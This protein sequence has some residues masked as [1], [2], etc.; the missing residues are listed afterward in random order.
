M[1]GFDENYLIYLRKSR[2]DLEAEAR[3]EGET[4]ARHERALLELAR[5]QRLNVT[6]IYRE[7]VSGETIASRPVMQQVLSE[8]EE[9][10][11]AGVIVMEVE[12]LARG[13]TIDQG[14]IAQTFKFSD[15]KIITPSKTYDPNNEFD[16][17][18][19]EFGLFMSRREYTVIRRRL[20]NGKLASVREG[21]WISH[22]APYGYERKKLE[23]E[24]GWVLEPV[25]EEAEVVRM[26]FEL[27]TVGLTGEDGSSS[28]MTL[29]GICKYFHELCIP[30]PGGGE[31]RTD[32]LSKMIENPVYCGKVRYGRLKQKKKVVDG[33]VVK[34]RLPAEE[35]EYIV[36][37]GRHPPIVSEETY[38]LA[39]EIRR[40]SWHPSPRKGRPLQTPL[41]GLVFC[42]R[43]GH[44]L[45]R[46]TCGR[47]KEYQLLSCRTF[48]C[49][50]IGSY[51][52]LVEERILS[53]LASWLDGYE[54]EWEAE[55]PALTQ[56][57]EQKKKALSRA[58]GELSRL[59]GQLDKTHDLLE[60]GV[61]DTNTFL[62]RSRL[63]ASKIS[64]MRERV[65]AL[66][67]EVQE[68]ARNERHRRDLVPR[69]KNVLEVYHALPDAAHKNQLLKEVVE[70]VVYTKEKV[71]GKS[72]PPD[73]FELDIYPRIPKKEE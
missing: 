57:L 4:L 17:E 14:I 42:S 59:Y 53:G 56:D 67:S 35:G 33:R 36:A 58:E 64:E 44:A 24:K 26:I 41:A 66:S 16:E 48:G 73:A 5:R 65:D 40:K 27:Y 25:P 71:D 46:I 70:R 13:D 20:E 15:T 22:L 23:H 11:W 38:N 52:P 12:R 1:E 69:V 51:L 6:A 68:A 37:P 47:D 54:L 19:F 39:N 43:C 55:A 3:G 34:V 72:P 18:Y 31:W 7:I 32:T 62:S 21:K 8:V 9:G 10:L 60:Q 61:Y 2:K 29:R 63:L 50:T 45:I 30:G 49:P 28:P